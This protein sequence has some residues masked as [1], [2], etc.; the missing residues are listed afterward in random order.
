VFVN[1]D[2]FSGRQDARPLRQARRLTLQ[3]PPGFNLAP[4][5]TILDKFGKVEILSKVPTELDRAVRFNKV[6]SELRFL[7]E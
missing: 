6:S 1:A 2:A 5:A 3:A 4:G 7:Y